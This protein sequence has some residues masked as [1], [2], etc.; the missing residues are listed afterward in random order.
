VRTAAVTV[1]LPIYNGERFLAECIRS[2]K[3]QTFED[4]EVIAVLDGCTDRSEEILM[5]MRDERFSVIKEDRNE[6]LAAALNH[7]L[8]DASAPLIARMD[9]D[10]AMRPDRFEQQ[11][12]WLAH[13]PQI[14]VLGTWFDYINEKGKRVQKAFPFPTMHE[15]IKRGFRVRNSIGGPTVMFRTERIRRIGGYRTDFPLAQDLALWLSCLAADFHLANLPTVLYSYRRYG[16]QASRQRRAEQLRLTNL[17][18]TQYGPEIW[19]GD[20]P[21]SERGL[22]LGRRIVKKLR[23]IVT[24]G[25]RW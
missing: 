9:A 23:R 11:F 7:A 4:F 21:E 3:A 19:G 13:E 8:A 2:I 12:E 25:T 6:G 17:A 5:D 1:A 24:G 22:P 16:A 14:D 18:Y 20:A 15:D 10:D